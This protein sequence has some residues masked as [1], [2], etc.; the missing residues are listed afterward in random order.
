ME[1]CTFSSFPCRLFALGCMLVLRSNTRRDAV[2]RGGN[3]YTAASPFRHLPLVRFIFGGMKRQLLL[4][5]LQ[6]EKTVRIIWERVGMGKCVAWGGKHIF[7]LLS[8]L[9]QLKYSFRVE[10]VQTPFCFHRQK[11]FLSYCI[12]YRQRELGLSIS[13]G[14]T[15]GETTLWY[16]GI[17]CEVKLYKFEKI[18]LLSV[19]SHVSGFGIFQLH[20]YYTNINLIILWMYS[21]PL[22]LVK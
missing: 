2:R 7:L 8:N 12:N 1:W 3:G 14:E 22:F 20:I 10:E 21:I 11:Y 4:I 6:K 17:F 16:V 9:C 18:S 15:R 13:I 19:K 5:T